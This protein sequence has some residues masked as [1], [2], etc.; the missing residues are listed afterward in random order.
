VSGG[1]GGGAARAGACIGACSTRRDVWLC[2]HGQLMALDNP[3]HPVRI[4]CLQAYQKVTHG[5]API[6]FNTT[7]TTPIIVWLII[8]LFRH[9]V[10]VPVLDT[11]LCPLPLPLRG[12]V[13]L[14][15]VKWKFPHHRCHQSPA[16]AF[17]A[18]WRHVLATAGAEE[19]RSQHFGRALRQQAPHHVR[20]VFLGSQ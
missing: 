13:M 11:L 20:G 7:G 9:L 15:C 6:P 19:T 16:R 5:A 10:C 12:C 1:D 4:E 14:C 2:Y 3:G 18:W 8:P 17:H